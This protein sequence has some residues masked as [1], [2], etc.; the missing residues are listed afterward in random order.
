MS[1]RVPQFA[2]YTNVSKRVSIRAAGL[3]RKAPQL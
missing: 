1:W 2:V 3:P